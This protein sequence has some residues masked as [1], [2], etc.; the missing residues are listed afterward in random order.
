MKKF[1]D[2]IIDKKSREQIDTLKKQ[3]DTLKKDY[4]DFQKINKWGK[5]NIKHLWHPW[6][7]KVIWPSGF[8]ILILLILFDGSSNDTNNNKKKMV[9]KKQVRM[10]QV[11]HSITHLPD[12]IIEVSGLSQSEYKNLCLNS[13]GKDLPSWASGRFTS[14]NTIMMELGAPYLAQK[15]INNGGSFDIYI[16]NWKDTKCVGSFRVKG[17]LDGV[18]RTVVMSGVV[19]KFYNKK[20]EDMNYRIFTAVDKM[21]SDY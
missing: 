8:L 3:I 18:E 17:I 21:V 14:L 5:F 12:G 11:E 19:Y 6:T 10:T 2:K 16:V 13:V 15:I 4:A 9:E 20:L 1:I 7:L